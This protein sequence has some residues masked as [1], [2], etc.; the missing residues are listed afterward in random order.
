MHNHL[1]MFNIVLKGSVADPEPDKV[2]SGLFWVTRIRIR[3][4]KTGSAD[5]DP[6]KNGPDPQHCE[7]M[8][9]YLYGSLQCVWTN[10]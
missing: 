5:P 9:L 10:S 6:E 3:N 1:D 8:M 7:R 4:L 2:G